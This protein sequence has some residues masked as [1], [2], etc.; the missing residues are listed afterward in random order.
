MRQLLAACPTCESLLSAYGQAR[1]Q[2]EKKRPALVEEYDSESFAQR[3]KS[4]D[5]NW[6]KCLQLRREILSHLIRHDKS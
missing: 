4:Y 2:F 5:D 1:F 3:E 6:E